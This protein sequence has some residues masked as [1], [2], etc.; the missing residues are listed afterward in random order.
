[1]PK[2][3][4]WDGPRYGDVC[5]NKNGVS[6]TVVPRSMQGRIQGPVDGPYIDYLVRRNP[7]A[8]GR[9]QQCWITTWAAW[10]R[11][12]VREGGTYVSAEEG[13]T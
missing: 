10:C 12:A 9:Q 1:M 13:G 4:P 7:N 11:R 8:A 5:T 6:R 2:F 3:Q